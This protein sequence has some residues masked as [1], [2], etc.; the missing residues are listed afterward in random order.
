MTD[1]DV[2]QLSLQRRPRGIDEAAGHSTTAHFWKPFK[3]AV[4]TSAILTQTSKEN[5]NKSVNLIKFHALAHGAHGEPSSASS[6]SSSSSSTI[7]GANAQSLEHDPDQ[8]DKGKQLPK[9]NP[10]TSVDSNNQQHP[11][12]KTPTTSPKSERRHKG[13]KSGDA[14]KSTADKGEAQQQGKGE[15]GTNEDGEEE[16]SP[17]GHTRSGTSSSAGAAGGKSPKKS[18]LSSFRLVSTKPKSSDDLGSRRRAKERASKKPKEPKKPKKEKNKDKD[19]AGG[20]GGDGK[21]RRNM[22]GRQRAS[23]FTV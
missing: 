20:E 19:D 4:A 17:S 9:D 1:E 15:K 7:T 21:T 22:W 11:H 13:S 2:Y 8:D 5:L 12:Q 23:T 14:S 16:I 10:H 6:S 18:L 3:Q